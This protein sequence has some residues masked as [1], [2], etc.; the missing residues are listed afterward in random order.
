M[1]IVNMILQS[2]APA[3]V[4]K[5]A[6]AIGINPTLAQKVIGAAL[7]AILAG[8][9]GKVGQPGGAKALGDVIGQQDAGVLGKLGDLIGGPQQKSLAE[10]G[11]GA[12][13]S[14][15][16]TGGVGA[17]AGTLGKFAGVNESQSSGLLGML[18]PVVLGTLGQ[19][20]KASGLDATGLANMLVGQKDNIAAAMPADFAKMLGGSGLMD[21]LG[22]SLS[23]VG[24]AGAAA[25]AVATSTAAAAA[26]TAGGSAAKG[27]NWLPWVIAVL[28][29]GL[30]W[31]YVFGGSGGKP[32][33]ITL[34]PAPK[35]MV[36]TLDLGGDLA[37]ALDGFKGSLAGV[38]DAASAQAALP[39]LRAAQVAIDKV[40]GAAGQLPAD[41]RKGLASYAA[42]AL[43][44]FGPMIDGILANSAAGPVLKPVVD[45]IRERLMALSKV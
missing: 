44:A 34:P 23:K 9:L 19:Q 4:G 26:S 45:Q 17:L 28:A 5:L 41:A 22:S 25:S 40:S 31:W 36:G 32:V 12:L 14:L 38:K 13:G 16:G 42:T 39:Q 18:A 15:L 2:L 27:F 6:S 29:A 33:A 43:L 37:K 24:T 20:Q 1:N 10:S 30:V 11:M 7:P 3:I 35:A 21:G 8:I